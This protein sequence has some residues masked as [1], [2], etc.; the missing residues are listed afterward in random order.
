[1]HFTRAAKLLAII[2]SYDFIFLKHCTINIIT[3]LGN[4]ILKLGMRELIL[5]ILIADGIP[6][7]MKILIFI[8]IA[9]DS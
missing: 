9:I 2:A 5:G 8:I 3:L 6:R 1:M 7:I 4:K